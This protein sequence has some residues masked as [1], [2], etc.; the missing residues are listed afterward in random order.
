[1]RRSVTYTN[2][3]TVC[4]YHDVCKVSFVMRWVNLV[5]LFYVM[6]L[7]AQSACYGKN[8]SVLPQTL[9]NMQEIHGY[10]VSS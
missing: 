9:W 8:N 4:R 7:L 10:E 3:Y 5:L 6:V 1:M 2:T